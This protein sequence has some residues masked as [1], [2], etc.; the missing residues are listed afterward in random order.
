MNGL[1][2]ALAA[3]PLGTGGLLGAAGRRGNPVAAAVAVAAAVVTLALAAAA[4]VL[5]PAASAPL[6]AGIEAAVAVDGLSAVMV[7]TVAGVTAAVI[8]FSVGEF[9][10]K[11]GAA[12]FFGLMLAFA[13]AMLL[14]VTAATVPLLLM[15]WE[16]MGAT[17]WALIGY[18][19]TEPDRVR[20]ANLAF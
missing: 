4:A 6:L 10:G 20:A 1:A 2:W 11:P 9:A 18:W 19:W 12:R 15:G 16:A 5:R 8:V 7:L 13:G 3:V 14:T 17:S